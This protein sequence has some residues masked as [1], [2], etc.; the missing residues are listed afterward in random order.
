M[1]H[2]GHELLQENDERGKRDKVCV[3]GE[4]MYYMCLTD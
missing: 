3:K 4:Y 2:P 1:T